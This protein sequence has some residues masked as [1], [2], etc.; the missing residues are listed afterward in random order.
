MDFTS[1]RQGDDRMIQDGFDVIHGAVSDVTR[2]ADLT[3]LQQ[4]LCHQLVFV[5]RF[6]EFEYSLRAGL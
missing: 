2:W 3:V 5:Q 6:R 1:I 4:L